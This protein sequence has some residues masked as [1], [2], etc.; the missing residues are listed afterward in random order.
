MASME[1]GAENYGVEVDGLQV[2]GQ[3]STL[4]SHHVPPKVTNYC[5]FTYLP[6]YQ[7]FFRQ[8]PSL[9]GVSPSLPLV[10]VAHFTLYPPI[11]VGSIYKHIFIC[12]AFLTTQHVPYLS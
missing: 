11:G 1:E 8:F 3:Q 10:L 2:V 12:N 4:H 5:P 9:A 6:T 7:Y